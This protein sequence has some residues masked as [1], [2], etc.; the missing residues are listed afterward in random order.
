MNGFTST[1]EFQEG[2]ITISNFL[3]TNVS[4]VANKK[5]LKNNLKSKRMS[6]LES[7]IES[8]PDETFLKADG[9][10]EAIIGVEVPS[11]RL[12]YSVTKVLDILTTDDEMEM[13]DA[14]EHFDFNIRGS[15]V[16]EQTPIWIEDNF[17]I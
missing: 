10:D 8:Y 3:F 7:I 2:K 16:G 14:L 17:L 15:Y 1:S 4:I 11:M 13:E 9:L 6:M 12:C 5:N